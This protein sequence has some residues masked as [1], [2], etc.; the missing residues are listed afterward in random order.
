MKTAVVIPTFNEEETV[1][2]V[3]DSVLKQGY[4]VYLI[5]GHS[6]DKTLEIARSYNVNVISDNGRGKG[7]ALRLALKKVPADVIVFMDADGSHEPQDIAN[8]LLPITSGQ[9][10]MVI[11]SRIMGGSDEANISPEH[12]IRSVGSQ[13]VACIIATIFKVKLTDVENGFRAVNRKKMLASGLKACDFTI[14]QEMVIRALRSGMRVTETASHEY[15]RKGGVAKLHTSEGWKFIVNL[16]R[17]LW[18]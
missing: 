3:L 14:E 17:A 18:F 13:I 5:D 10:D 16:F 6:Q 12:L 4:E 8:L 11:G 15:A 7:A 9:A 1:G 2:D